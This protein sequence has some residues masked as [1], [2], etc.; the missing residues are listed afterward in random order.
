MLL[1][2]LLLALQAPLVV[3][4][5]GVYPTIAAAVAAA[6][7]G[8]TVRVTRG[9]WREPTIRLERPIRLLGEPGAV[10]DGEGARELVV[11]L[12]P[13][14]TV[15]G[16]TFRNTGNSYHEDR[17]ALH[18]D[19]VVGCVIVRNRFEDTFFAIYLSRTTSCIVRENVV[20]G[21]P[22]TES[23]T[24]NAVH[25]WGSRELRIEGNRLEGHRDGV[26]L[27]FTRHATVIDNHSTKNLRYGLH[28]MYS[29]SS[30]YTGN[31]FRGN[32]SGVAVMY[33]HDVQMVNNRFLDNRGATAYGLL[34][35]EIAD[36]HLTGNEFG[37]N[38][39]GLLADGA[40]RVQVRDNRFTR[41]GWAIRLLASTSDGVFANNTFSGNSFD[42]A[43]NSRT[44]GAE[45]AGNF[46]DSYRGWDLDHDGTGDVPHHPVRLFGTLVERAPAALTLQRSLFVRAL[47]A[48]ERVL[49]VLTPR[50][51]VDNA[52]RMTRDAGRMP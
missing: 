51:V 18:A 34:L 8:G 36:V 15:E 7:D 2:T 3:T 35:K 20:I 41:N 26:Y 5:G 13:D 32:G 28:F 52:P 48:A 10:L 25:S 30:S 42:V 33:S 23:A 14:V 40:E 19:E 22:T 50:Q 27:E 9:V 11:I 29:D 16:L 31:E 4:P 37:N 21:H 17:A 49:P 12:A 24:G 45:F 44:V 39:T 1:T 47:D 43:V 38:T 6:P 46:W